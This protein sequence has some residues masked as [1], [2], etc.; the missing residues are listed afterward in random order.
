MSENTTRETLATNW[1]LYGPPPGE[2]I[3]TE[4]AAD[5]IGVSVRRVR[6]MLRTDVLRG[7]KVG[8]DWLIFRPEVEREFGMVCLPSGDP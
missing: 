2:W 7:R 8:R 6:Q 5:V 1:A 4:E 3:R